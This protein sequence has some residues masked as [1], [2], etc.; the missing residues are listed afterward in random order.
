MAEKKLV[1]LFETYD[2]VAAY[3]KVYG[4]SPTIDEIADGMALGRTTVFHRLVAMEI[5]GMIRRESRV[6]RGIVLVA[7]ET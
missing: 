5:R 1:R 7:R 4:V 6:A 3:C 2:F